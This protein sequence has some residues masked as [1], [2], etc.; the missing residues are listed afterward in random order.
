LG[1]NRN[2]KIEENNE[3]IQTRIQ[4]QAKRGGK[5]IRE[6]KSKHST[7]ESTQGQRLFFKKTK[8]EKMN[9]QEPPDVASREQRWEYLRE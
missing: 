2:S 7:E 1:Y 4:R 3:C 5:D 6:D 8:K 9:E